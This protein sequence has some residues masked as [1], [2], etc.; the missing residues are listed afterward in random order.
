LE[1]DPKATPFQKQ[2]IS[3]RLELLRTLGFKQDKILEDQAFWAAD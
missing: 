1:D 2:S 3:E